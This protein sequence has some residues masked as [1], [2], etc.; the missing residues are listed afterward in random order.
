M[1][2]RVYIVTLA[3]IAAGESSRLKQEG[4]PGLKALVRVG[5]VSLIETIIQSGLRAG[6][7]RLCC[8]INEQSSDLKVY[9]CSRRCSVPL[10]L[11][12]ETTPS[13]MHS[14][15]ALAQVIVR[16]PIFMATRF[17]K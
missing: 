12:V 7:D 9:L 14:L 6:A 5:A 10:H 1:T 2:S 8:I 11:T 16:Q 4:L 15:F 17:P 13:S 3:I